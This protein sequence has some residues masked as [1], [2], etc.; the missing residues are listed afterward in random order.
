MRAPLQPKIASDTAP[1][2]MQERSFVDNLP[3][4]VAQRRTIN[5]PYSGTVQRQGDGTVPVELS[6]TQLP[7][8]LEDKTNNIGLPNQ[9]RSGIE[10]LAGMRMDHVKVHYNSSKPAQLQAQA[11][12]QG[13][14]IYVGPGQEKHLPHEAWHLVQQAQ[15]R[16][17]PTMQMQAG[18]INDD[19]LLEKEADR[20]GKAAAQRKL[21]SMAGTSSQAVALMHQ[22]ARLTT[23]RP[24]QRKITDV[25]QQQL[26]KDY[27][28][29][30][31][32]ANA[33]STTIESLY[34]QV[35][36]QAAT[37]EEARQLADEKKLARRKI[38]TQEAG[39]GTDYD[40]TSLAA[41]K[42]EAMREFDGLPGYTKHKDA[43][44]YASYYTWH[45]LVP[46][47]RVENKAT[48]STTAAVRL[49]PSASHRY[50]DPGNEYLDSN[51]SLLRDGTLTPDSEKVEAYHESIRS[52]GG[53][54]AALTKK[55]QDLADEIKK[56]NHRGVKKPLADA[57]QWLIFGDF[58]RALNGMT[59]TLLVE[60]NTLIGPGYTA[61]KG[62]M[63]SHE[64]VSWADLREKANPNDVEGVSAELFAV[65]NSGIQAYQANSPK[66]IK[67]FARGYKE[68]NPITLEAL[69]RKT[70]IDAAWLNSEGEGPRLD[71]ELETLKDVKDKHAAII[72]HAHLMILTAK[73]LNKSIQTATTKGDNSYFMGNEHAVVPGSGSVSI[74]QASSEA[75]AGIMRKLARLAPKLGWHSAKPGMALTATQIYDF[76][77]NN[78]QEY[79]AEQ[80]SDAEINDAKTKIQETL[81]ATIKTRTALG[82]LKSKERRKVEETQHILIDNAYREETKK[83]VKASTDDKMLTALATGRLEEESRKRQTEEHK[84]KVIAKFGTEQ[85]EHINAVNLNSSTLLNQD[86][87]HLNDNDP[88]AIDIKVEQFCQ[89]YLASA[90]TTWLDELKQDI[91]ALRFPLPPGETLEVV[92][93]TD[94]QSEE[95]VYRLKVEACVSK[96]LPK[97]S[98][99]ITSRGELAAHT[100]KQP[101]L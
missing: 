27:L 43:E 80:F 99:L 40:A 52:K 39:T 64:F 50:G 15:G 69:K 73:K 76:H 28:I 85:D 65:L 100:L 14:E 88:T 34:A 70:R 74:N 1:K 11:Y 72:M 98:A 3:A 5:G 96:A 62:K 78:T 19:P 82:K 71:D 55:I 29:K 25:Q 83:M 61:N 81:A 6:P 16:V 30:I 24:I 66:G 57:G 23:V 58:L 51:Y 79:V 21:Q 44:K 77:K 38:L 31:F 7:T 33:A 92:D 9:L 12:A 91:A 18:M 86:M 89:S 60:L 48:A 59:P 42:I 37:I 26:V 75:A 22:K 4:A 94:W 35:V 63:E 84:G 54:A 68:A 56:N 8:Q 32:G 17:R 95:Q 10:S 20:M 45:H 90:Y 49:G 93:E 46:Q 87:L 101:D 36:E 97:M 2:K 47:S 53:L 13:S 41:D 67:I